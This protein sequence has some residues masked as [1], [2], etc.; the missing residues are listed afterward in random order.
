MKPEKLPKRNY[1]NILKYFRK[2]R[3]PG[4]YDSWKIIISVKQSGRIS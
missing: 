3:I 1:Q 4:Y 2:L